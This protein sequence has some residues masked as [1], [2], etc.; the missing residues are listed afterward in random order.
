MEFLDALFDAWRFFLIVSV[1]LAGV[2]AFIGYQ[3]GGPAGDHVGIAIG[4]FPGGFCLVGELA[5]AFRLRWARRARRLAGYEDTSEPASHMLTGRVN[6][7]GFILQLF[8]GSIATV[9]A[10]ALM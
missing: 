7:G 4:A 5:T 2:L 1:A 8:G 9:L 10:L 3:I 6:D